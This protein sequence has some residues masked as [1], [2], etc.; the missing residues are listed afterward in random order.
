[1]FL[2]DFF[3][4][5]APVSVA[6]FLLGLAVASTTFGAEGKPFGSREN[7]I[8]PQ[9]TDDPFAAKTE[10]ERQRER[11][12]L[13]AE[14]AI[15]CARVHGII[16][17]V[18]D[19][20]DPG[21]LLD[22]IFSRLN[23]QGEYIRSAGA[24][25]L[26]EKLLRFPWPR[27]EN[28]EAEDIAARVFE[29]DAHRNHELS[30]YL[31]HYRERFRELA[32]KPAAFDW[33]ANR[34]HWRRV[35]VELL[36]AGEADDLPHH[37]RSRMKSGRLPEDQMREIYLAAVRVRRKPWAGE[38]V[39][40]LELVGPWLGETQT[41]SRRSMSR[42]AEVLTSL[43]A[44]GAPDDHP[45]RVRLEKQLL[46]LL[47]DPDLSESHVLRD[48]GLLP[49]LWK[50]DRSVG[51]KVLQVLLTR[52]GMLGWYFARV[53]GIERQHAEDLFWGHEIRFDGQPVS[54]EDAISR[55][56]GGRVWVDAETAADDP[57]VTLRITASRMAVL[58]AAAAAA[59]C[60]VA[61]FQHGIVWVG[62]KS[63]RSV[64]E[65][66]LRDALGR[67]PLGNSPV[68]TALVEN[69]QI[70]FIETPLA[71]VCDYLSD[72]HSIQV[73]L[74]RPVDERRIT[75]QLTNMPLFLALTLLT[76]AAD[77]RWTTAENMILIG[78]EKS[79]VE[80]DPLHEWWRRRRIRLRKL[81]LAG[82]AVAAEMFQPTTMEFIETPLEDVC[83]YLADL[84]AQPVLLLSLA[85]GQIP[86][87]TNLNG[88]NLGWAMSFC[89]WRGG[90]TWD[91]DGEIVFIGRKEDVR[92]F[93][94]LADTRPQ[95]RAKYAEKLAGKLQSEYE[96]PTLEWSLEFF[97][98]E[99]GTESGITVTPTDDA[100]RA[101]HRITV[102]PRQYPLDVTL[103]LISHRHGLTW[104]IR[105][106]E[107]IIQPE[108]SSSR[109]RS[110]KCPLECNE[111]TRHA[112]SDFFPR[113][114]HGQANR[115]KEKQP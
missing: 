83:A 50:L 3:S 104:E 41:Y 15:L 80:F 1:M 91:T 82:S 10:E 30:R 25:S 18:S 2:L 93:R 90:L 66:K 14:L 67:V 86:I 48:G 58:E 111:K 98:D 32:G 22:G 49:R 65:K 72:L 4:R 59:K 109:S 77:L 45:D 44:A 103:D 9:N 114:P 94:E 97:C 38:K 57:T 87:T 108:P 11:A 89:L 21:A 96:L 37:I 39:W 64:A 51:G 20:D 85:N 42:T 33:Q 68:R 12:V 8:A 52:H 28:D 78:D 88:L 76:E 17:R 24:V 29:S 35:F 106:E 73:K 61:H 53:A 100:V 110:D 99:L 34:A 71:D 105:G 13:E 69:T 23:T 5:C 6:V 43:V 26:L 75:Q 40:D 84:H 112:R 102:D 46:A 70:E 7:P 60:E 54:L 47:A 55:I 62:P 79:I 16:E 63:K 36:E 74:P 19:S 113:V 92:R 107:V 101:D 27:E 115:E 56:G 81:E 31:Q 95:R